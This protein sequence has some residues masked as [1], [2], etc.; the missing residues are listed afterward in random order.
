MME[1]PTTSNVIALRTISCTWITILKTFF[2]LKIFISS[3]SR[4]NIY[5]PLSFNQPYH[6]KDAQSIHYS[7]KCCLPQENDI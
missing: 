4:C 6:H 1:C 2:D 3:P 5:R 7:K